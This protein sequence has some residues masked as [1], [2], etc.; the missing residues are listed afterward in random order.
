MLKLSKMLYIYTVNTLSEASMLSPFFLDSTDLTHVWHADQLSGTTLP[1]V[2]TGFARLD[3]A[4]PGGGWPNASMTEVLQPQMGLHEWGLLLP[5]LVATQK[6]LPRSLT[7]MAGGPL[8]PFAPP[9][10]A[11]DFDMR[12]LLRVGSDKNDALALLWAAREALQCADVGAVLAWLPGVRSA[13]LRRLQIAAHTH[14]KLL[15]VF[16]PVAARYESSPAPLRLILQA[17]DSA[18]NLQVTVLKRRGPPMNAPVLIDT[19]PERLTAFLKA[20]QAHG[21]RMRPSLP[22]LP[23]MP[24]ITVTPIV[25]LSDLL[26]KPLYALDRVT[27]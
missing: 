23:K 7:V 4:L 3:L 13:H 2:P 14:N 12:R 5:A 18:A 6:A 15:F 21:R 25:D 19:R 1:S 9:L 27:N 22:V 10:S 20:S 8:V 26:R 24:A 17:T 16:R 11:Q